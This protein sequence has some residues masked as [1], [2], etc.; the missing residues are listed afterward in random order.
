MSRY[1]SKALVCRIAK[2]VDG[3]KLTGGRA[4]IISVLGQIQE[5]FGELKIIG[6]HLRDV[7]FVMHEISRQKQSPLIILST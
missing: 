7:E 6:A 1:G 2:H 5:L 3:L 4:D